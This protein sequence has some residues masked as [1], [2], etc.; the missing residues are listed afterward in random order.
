MV[1]EV[2]WESGEGGKVGEWLRRETAHPF[3]SACVSFKILIRLVTL[4]PFL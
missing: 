1:K 2:R 4:K 3:Y